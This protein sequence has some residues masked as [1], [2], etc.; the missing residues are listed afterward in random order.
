MRATGEDVALVMQHARAVDHALGYRKWELDSTVIEESFLSGT[1]TRA[2]FLIDY[3][4]AADRFYKLGL[5]S[6]LRENDPVPAGDQD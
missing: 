2:Q 5:A 3:R 4:V 1:Y 6:Q